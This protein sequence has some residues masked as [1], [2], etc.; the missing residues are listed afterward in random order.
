MMKTQ[1]RVKNEKKNCE[2]GRQLL[3][4]WRG[5]KI[6]RERTT[7]SISHIDTICEL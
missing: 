3:F 5:T 6:F 4:G 1:W 7:I 2:V